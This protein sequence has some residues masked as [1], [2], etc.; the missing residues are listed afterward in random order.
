MN[1][2]SV[3]VRLLYVALCTG[4]LLLV[5]GVGLALLVTWAELAVGIFS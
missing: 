5:G 3:R 4:R 2:P 1:Q